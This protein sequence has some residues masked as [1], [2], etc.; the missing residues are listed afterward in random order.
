MDPRAALR[1]W[2][3]DR[4]LAKAGALIKCDPSLLRKLESSDAE[5]NENRRPGLELAIR[6]RDVVGIPIE[7]WRA[8]SQS[9]E[10]PAVEPSQ[11]DAAAE[12]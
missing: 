6:I 10:H 11:S 3:G 12:R 1:K 2:R 9:G 7:A 8:S 4:S 5:Q